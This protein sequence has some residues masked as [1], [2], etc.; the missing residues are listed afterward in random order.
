LKS[1]VL[2]NG[3]SASVANAPSSRYGVG[4]FTDGTG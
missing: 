1:Y 3:F 4:Q 2:A